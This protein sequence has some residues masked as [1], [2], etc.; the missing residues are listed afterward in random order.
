MIVDLERRLTGNTQKSTCL[1]VVGGVEDGA[2]SEA[3]PGEATGHPP[4]HVLYV[5]DADTG[6]CHA[7]IEPVSVPRLLELLGDHVK[8]PGDKPDNIKKSSEYGGG[9]GYN[10]DNVTS[11]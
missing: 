3:Q 5:G 9:G 2:G 11:H 7:V 10:S 1:R 6:L 8:H 4:G